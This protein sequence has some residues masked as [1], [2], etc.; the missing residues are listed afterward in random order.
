[1]AYQ[2]NLEFYSRKQG[3]AMAHLRLSIPT[4]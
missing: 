4:A 3:I 2:S 1:M